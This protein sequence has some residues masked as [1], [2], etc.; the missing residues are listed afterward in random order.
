MH[1][2]SLGGKHSNEEILQDLVPKV[3]HQLADPLV[4]GGLVAREARAALAVGDAGED[5]LGQG[6]RVGTVASEISQNIL[7]DET[8][9]GS[10]LG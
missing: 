10:P 4:A 2:L 5:A 9:L 6:K 3:V 8:E 7:C 1:L